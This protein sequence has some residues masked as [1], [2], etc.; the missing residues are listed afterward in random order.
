MKRLM[1]MLVVLAAI[2]AVL[3]TAATA[4]AA[5]P[6]NGGTIAFRRYLNAEQTWAAIFT[7]RP[8][9]SSLRRVTHPRRGFIHDAPDWSPNGR[10]IAFTRIWRGSFLDGPHVDGHPNAIFRI[11]P[12]GRD[13]ENLSR[14]V[15]HPVTCDG[16]IL[17]SWS[18]SGRWIAFTRL[19]PTDRWEKRAGVSLIRLDG[20]GYR[21]VTPPRLGYRDIGPSWSPD[22]KRLA[23]VRNI[24]SACG[25]PHADDHAIFIV[26][27]NGSH[28]RRITP[29]NVQGSLNPDWSPNGRWIVFTSVTTDPPASRG[30]NVWMIHPN[31]TGLRRLTSNPNDLYKFGRASFS[32]D[33]QRVTTSRGLGDGQRDIYVMNIDGS[34][35]HAIVTSPRSDSFPDW[36]RGRPIE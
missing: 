27:L 20:S 36:G 1:S 16:D 15:C 22:G 2:S 9:G 34:D 17:P 12:S 35:F 8:D 31:G 5:G 10:W 19:Y 32:P 18:P 29:W 11:R 33:G 25:C 24:D 3:L 30:V 6:G 14:A 26:R 13:R 7:V 23:F 4:H 21:Q 28:L